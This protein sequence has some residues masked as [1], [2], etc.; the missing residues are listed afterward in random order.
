MELRPADIAMRQFTHKFRG[1]DPD[2]V[3]QFLTDVAAHLERV[4]SELTRV[5][6]ERTELQVNLKKALAEADD[7]RKQLAN[8]QDKITAHHKQESQMAQALLNAQKVTDDLIQSSKGRAD[9]IVA[10]A[11]ANALLATEAA[12][13]EAAEAKTTAQ[14]TL[15]AARKEAAELLRATQA[16]AQEAVSSRSGSGNP[17]PSPSERRAASH[18]SRASE[19]SRCALPAAQPVVAGRPRSETAGSGPSCGPHQLAAARCRRA[20][21]RSRRRRVRRLARR[22]GPRPA[23]RG[24]SVLPWP[25]LRRP[26]GGDAGVGRL[27]ARSGTSS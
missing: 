12:R 4:S 8:T 10:E 27:P 5:T 17:G 24:R 22:C 7:L 15:E 18:R 23:G 6:L 25:G 13:K 3:K 1:V 9:R 21:G 19:P 2:E 26:S 14:T 16:Q 11:K 20:A